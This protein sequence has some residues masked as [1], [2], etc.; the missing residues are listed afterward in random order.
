MTRMLFVLI[1]AL[2]PQIVLGQG[3]VL[4]L[5][6]LIARTL[7]TGLYDG[8]LTKQVRMLGDAAAVTLTKVLGEKSLTDIEV[9]TVLTVVSDA[10][11]E[12]TLVAVVS[13]REPRTALL[14]LKYLDCRT[15]SSST[16]KQ[17]VSETRKYVLD[18]FLKAKANQ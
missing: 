3:R 12:L 8:H 18:A 2:G 10:F 14:L 1:C 5:E 9:D 13:D 17:R 6:E 4:S 16:L 11:S 7:S 15:E